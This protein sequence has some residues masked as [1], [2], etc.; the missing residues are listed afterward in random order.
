MPREGAGFAMFSTVS[1]AAPSAGAG[2]RLPGAGNDYPPNRAGILNEAPAGPGESTQK[3]PSFRG[4]EEPLT[5]P[6]V[7]ARPLR[8]ISRGLRST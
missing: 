2:Q 3:T 4:F 6:R 5:S 7:L 1:A 8:S